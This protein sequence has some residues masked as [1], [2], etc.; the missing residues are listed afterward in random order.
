MEDV[1]FSNKNRVGL[2]STKVADVQYRLA[3]IALLERPVL[4]LT[5]NSRENY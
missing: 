5:T 2:T 1:I 3:K 4:K